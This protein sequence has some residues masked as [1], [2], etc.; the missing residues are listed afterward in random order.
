MILHAGRRSDAAA[1]RSILGDARNASW[2]LFWLGT[3]N[4]PAAA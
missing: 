4:A 2:L 3:S 1:A